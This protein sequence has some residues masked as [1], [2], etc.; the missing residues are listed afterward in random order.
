MKIPEPTHVVQTNPPPDP[1][2]P[3]ELILKLSIYMTSWQWN[4]QCTDCVPFLSNLS[5]GKHNADPS[6]IHDFGSSWCSGS[7]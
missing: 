3:V 4:T 5:D 7:F 1:K 6:F 2:Y